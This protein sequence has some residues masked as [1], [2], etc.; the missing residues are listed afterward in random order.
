MEPI[1]SVLI[2]ITCIYFAICLV[3][4]VG[5]CIYVYKLSETNKHILK[6]KLSFQ[7]H[8]VKLDSGG[9]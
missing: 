3:Y 5:L 9:S 1:I 7:K 4:I 8:K 6:G 2:G